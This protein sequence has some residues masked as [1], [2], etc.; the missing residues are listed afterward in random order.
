MAMNTPIRFV[1]FLPGEFIVDPRSDYASAID[2]WWAEIDYSGSAT[3]NIADPSIFGLTSDSVTAPV[4][5]RSIFVRPIP[6]EW[7]AGDQ[8]SIYCWF[9]YEDR[10]F[11]IREIEMLSPIRWRLSLSEVPVLDGRQ[12]TLDPDA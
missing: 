10:T 2:N 5:L 7:L 11:S 4:E 12:Y 6:R 1:R 8:I 9:P 3:V